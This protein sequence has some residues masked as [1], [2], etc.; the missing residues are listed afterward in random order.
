[1]PHDMYPITSINGDVETFKSVINGLTNPSG[2][3]E[4]VK[5]LIKLC[6]V[7]LLRGIAFP[8]DVDIIIIIFC[9]SRTR[10]GLGFIKR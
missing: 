8:N 2:V 4:K 10:Y 3:Y 1:M 5:V 6:I 9:E 7:Y